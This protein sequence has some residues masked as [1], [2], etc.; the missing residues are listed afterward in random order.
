VQSRRGTRLVT[1]YILSLVASVSFLVMW[2]VYVVRSGLRIVALGRKVGVTQAGLDWMLLTFGCVL[3]ILLISGLTYQLAQA[4]AARRYALKADE[5]VANITHEMKSPLAAIKLHAQTL[6][7]GDLSPEMQRQFLGVIE[8]Q[9]DRMAALVDAVLE[10]SRLL[11]RRGKVELHPVDLGAFLSGYLPHARALAESR[12]VQLRTNVVANAPIL[13]TEEGLR[14]VLDNLI[15]NA[16]RFSRPGGEVRC[17]VATFPEGVRIEVEDDGVGIPKGELPNIFDRFYQASRERGGPRSGT[18]LGLSIVAGLV[19]EMGGTVRA[20]SHDERPG[21][22][23]VVDL[24]RI[25]EE[26]APTPRPELDGPPRLG[27]ETPERLSIERKETA[28]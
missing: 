19:K 9:V 24:P 20:F 7:Q 17:R 14:R 16:V 28:R 27:A 11:A 18:G 25:L 8:Q 2:V 22:T 4:L 6:H 15:D 13:G 21:T 12:D 23:L 3:L 10:S 5:F 26:T 1:I